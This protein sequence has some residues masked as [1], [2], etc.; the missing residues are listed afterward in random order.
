MTLRAE[1]RM[2]MH[3]SNCFHMETTLSRDSNMTL[4]AEIRM[5][6]HS[7][8]CFHGFLSVPLYS[9]PIQPNSAASARNVIFFF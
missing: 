3:S 1:I 6:M 4:R 9:G 2:H 8:N 7:S 5:H